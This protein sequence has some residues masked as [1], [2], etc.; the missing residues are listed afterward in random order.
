MIWH[1]NYINTHKHTHTHKPVFKFNSKYNSES[2]EVAKIDNESK[3]RFVHCNPLPDM[4][5]RFG[6]EN[7]AT[8][9]HVKSLK[10]IPNFLDLSLSHCGFQSLGE[11]SS[12]L[13]V[14]FVCV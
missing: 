13:F 7:D 12:C 14:Y 3:A 5:F 2:F 8:T 1:Q 6:D 9:I 4:R 10:S 11:Q